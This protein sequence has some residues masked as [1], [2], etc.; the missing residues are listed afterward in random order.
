MIALL[1]CRNGLWGLVR[2]TVM[3]GLVLLPQGDSRAATVW[4]MPQVFEELVA[5]ILAWGNGLRMLSPRS[6]ARVLAIDTSQPA[7]G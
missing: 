3:V 4:E 7:S 1:D 6:R 5:T 2:A